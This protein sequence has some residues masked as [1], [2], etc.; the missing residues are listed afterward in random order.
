MRAI[1]R[2]SVRPAADRSGSDL[3]AMPAPRPRPEPA[4]VEPLIDVTALDRA[5]DA[6]ADDAAGVARAHVVAAIK[7][8]IA[9]GRAVIER[10]FM[11]TQIGAEAVAAHAV[12]MDTVIQSLHRVIRTQIFPAANPTAGEHLAICAVG[13]YGRGELAPH[14]DLDLLFLLPYKQ[15]PLIE[16]TVEFLLYVLWDCGLKVGQATR[17][18][19][20]CL[21]QA[22]SDVTIRTALLEARFLAGDRPLFQLL[23]RRF[24]AEVVE[25]SGIA[26]VDAKLAERDLRHQKLGDSRYV[27]EPNI[28]EGKGGLR[29]LHG[30]LWIAKYLFHVTSIDELAKRGVL[31]EEEA[32]RFNRDQNFL[33]TVRCHLHYLAGRPEERLT[34]DV[35]TEIGRR[36]GYTDHAGARGVER[37]MKHYF[38]IAKDVG[39]L[40]R[41]FI[42]ALEADQKRKPTSLWRR[43]MPTSGNKAVEGFKIDGGRLNVASDNAFRTDPV[44]LIRLFHVAQSNRLEIHPRALRLVTQSLRLIDGRLRADPTA[45]KLFV[46][47]LTSRL[48]PE[49]TLRHLNEAGVFGRFVPDF[50]RVVAQMQYD[51]YHVYTVD[52]HTI[53]AIG[54]LAKM[55]RGELKEELPLISSMID[56]IASRRALY[57]ATLLHDIAKG[58]KC[59]HSEM[60]AKIAEK[61]GPRFGLTAEETETAAWLVLH[62]LDMSRT[63]FKRDVDDPQTV[64]DFVATVQSPERLKLLL[65]L[66]AADIRAVG[67]HVWNGWKGGLLRELYSR[68]QEVMSGNV[69]VDARDVRIAKVQADVRALLLE[70]DDEEFQR[71][72]QRGYPAYWLSH[73]PVTLARHARLMRQADRDGASL[74]VTHRIDAYRSVTEVT[75]YTA[76]HA[77]L[78]SRIAG[79]LSVAGAKIVDARIVTMA[80]GMALDTFWVQ[81]PGGG[82]FER[83]DKLAKL[84]VLL[85]NVLSG[86]LD[87]NVELKREPAYPSRM[88]VFT[89]PPRVLIDNKASASHTVIEVNGRDRPALLFDLTRALTSLGV[90]IAGAKIATYGE[91][92]VDVFFVKDVFGLKIE[93]DTK[94]N[95]IRKILYRVLEEGDAPRQGAKLRAT[96]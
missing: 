42:A 73:D 17:S 93:H 39:D 26:F 80:N 65:C 16:Q 70:F 11:E 48:D 2:R 38:L 30:L 83:G 31:S 86:K 13:G 49:S 5:L 90:Q 40:T 3:R 41:I 85:E 25:G 54:M 76:D 71:F 94:I 63:A 81:D 47:I 24:T 74:T 84:A 92:V 45:N 46:E 56:S 67:P 89:V 60:G 72:T 51:M 20:E 95:E 77:G 91:K 43:L 87:P 32:H 50:G 15:T 96:V 88:R 29:D 21:R 27:L 57:V 75:V 44:N 18:V 19:D 79:A 55:E 53:F 6:A 59:D 52:E 10:R 7:P 37:F 4:T 78:F 23:T 14:S 64:Q 8:V 66:T 33:W 58:R 28:K 22:Q 61:L 69:A 62:H 9:A 12:L 36:M 1:R 82:A 35:Q 68:A 34:F